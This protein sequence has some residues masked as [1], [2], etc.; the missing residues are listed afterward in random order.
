MDTPLTVI[1]RLQAK[2]GRGDELLEALTPLVQET[3]KETG[4]V[5]YDLYR[6][7]EDPTLFAFHETWASRE[8]W[9]AH[10]ASPHVSAFGARAGDLL[11]GAAQVDPLYPVA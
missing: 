7:P 11:D 9:E 10:N 4:C 1:A 2:P 3:R 5:H 8:H 6:S